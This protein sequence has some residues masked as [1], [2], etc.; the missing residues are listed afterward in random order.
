MK[1]AARP[2]RLLVEAAPALLPLSRKAGEEKAAPLA[3]CGGIASSKSGP[4]HS[5]SKIPAAPCP[6]P[7]HMVSMP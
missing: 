7:T 3:V 5:R 1:A 2:G 4:Y 6:V